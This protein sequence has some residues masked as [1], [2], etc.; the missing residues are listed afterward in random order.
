MAHRSM[1]VAVLSLV[2]KRC[3]QNLP[4]VLRLSLYSAFVAA[5]ERPCTTMNCHGNGVCENDPQNG[6]ICKCYGGHITGKFCQYSKLC[7]SVTLGRCFTAHQG[8][9]R[10]SLTYYGYKI[11]HTGTVGSDNLPFLVVYGVAHE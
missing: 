2:L 1:F 5:V 8:S 7:I 10:R 6:P 11:R 9:Y 4:Q 3:I